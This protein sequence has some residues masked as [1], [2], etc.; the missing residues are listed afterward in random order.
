MAFPDW[1]SDPSAWNTAR[2][3]EVS[4]PG[5]VTVESVPCGKS[6]DEKKRK[7]RDGADLTDNGIEPAKFK[8]ELWLTA[9]DWELWLQVLPKIDPRTANTARA[10]LELVHPLPNSMGVRTVYV[11]Q[12]EARSPSAQDGMKIIISVVQW[13][14]QTKPTK[15]S[16]TPK[17][18][19]A[20]Y[21]GNA[22][23]LARNLAA[24]QGFLNPP[25]G[26]DALAP[27]DPQNI[28]AN[29]YR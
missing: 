21:Q 17:L 4:L 14:P 24:R 25:V 6:I 5:I 3:G 8:V 18:A 10:P 11:K 20:N 27:N 2:L 16:T 9:E 29:L 12:I 1:I 22:L 15:T 7:G 23:D 26:V 13:F 19:P 28:L